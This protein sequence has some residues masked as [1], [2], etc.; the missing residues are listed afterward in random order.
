MLIGSLPM[1][2]NNSEIVY[3][4]LKISLKTK[5]LESADNTGNVL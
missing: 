3:I 1:K 2:I 4:M 5:S